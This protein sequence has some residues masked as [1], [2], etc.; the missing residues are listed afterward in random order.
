VWQVANRIARGLGY[1]LF[2]A[3]SEDGTV[4]IVVDAP[5]YAGEP[6]FTFMREIV[7]GTVTPASNILHGRESFNVR[8]VPTDVTVFG[9]AKRGD[10]ES[11]RIKRRVENGYLIN[12]DVTRGKVSESMP[13]QPRY[14]R[15]DQAKTQEGALKEAE[16]VLSEANER[17]RVYRC[18]VQG[19]GQAGRVYGPNIMSNVRDD[20]LGIRERMLLASCT[21][22][23]GHSTGQTTR[24]EL[25]PF[26]AL[27]VEPV[28]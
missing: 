2:V 16:R 10:V 27:S 14:L 19:H 20:K 6:L 28:T 4:N 8:D 15:S 26:G 21:F 22:S 3:P 5:N 23:G 7:D 12:P 17:F 11:A 18:A 25:V 1:R 13:R 24:A 9:S